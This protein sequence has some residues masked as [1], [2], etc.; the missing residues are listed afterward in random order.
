MWLFLLEDRSV[1]IKRINSVAELAVDRLRDKTAIVRKQAL[2]LLTS[3]LDNNP[4]SADLNVESFISKKIELEESLRL[5]ILFLRERSAP[6][7]ELDLISGK[8]IPKEPS[9]G[10]T[11]SGAERQEEG[12]GEEGGEEVEDGGEG[13]DDDD[14]DFADSDDVKQDADIIAL[15]GQL[16]YVLSVLEFLGTLSSAVVRMEE[17]GKSSTTTDVVEVM[18][19][20]VRS[21]NFNIKDSRTYLQN[22]F[23]QVWH[24]EEA[25]RNVCVACFKSAY[26]TD[27]GGSAAEYL[28]PDEVASNLIH[29]CQMCDCSELASLEQIVGILFEKEEVDKLVITALWG[30]ATKRGSVLTDLRNSSGALNVIAMIAKFVPNVL[31]SSKVQLVGENCLRHSLE[32][33]ANISGARRGSAGGSVGGGQSCRGDMSVS[34]RQGGKKGNIDEI[35]RHLI[36]EHMAILRSSCKCLQLCAISTSFSTSSSSPPLG[37]MQSVM[38]PCSVYLMDIVMGAFCDNDALITQKWFAVCEEAIMAIFQ[39]HPSPDLILGSVI[40]P[41]FGS[42]TGAFAPQ[43]PRESTS[44]LAS[45]GSKCVCSPSRLSR[46]LFVLGQSAL[47]V[48]VYAE[49]I[50]DLSKKHLEKKAIAMK[51]NKEVEKEVI[52]R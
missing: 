10:V 15:R 16:T 20:L 46:L 42:I 35:S 52:G 5:R 25:V 30:V 14:D 39:V 36:I 8:N 34:D 4:F 9:A 18:K 47:C 45:S 24:E 43:N 37:D 48:V 26:L 49:K 38:L 33:I 51:E 21:V 1:P 2:S 7:I 50:A 19:F 32:K 23:A 29:V 40:G 6:A 13:E 3:L 44:T 41:L 17:L 27:G 12:E 31:S 11:S 28:A 22:I